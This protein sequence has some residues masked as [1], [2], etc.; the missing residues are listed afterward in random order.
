MTY[1]ME[2]FEEKRDLLLMAFYKENKPWFAD[3][4]FV[5]KYEFYGYHLI[6]IDWIFMFKYSEYC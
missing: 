5:D 4:V 3:F 1:K 2:F 6:I